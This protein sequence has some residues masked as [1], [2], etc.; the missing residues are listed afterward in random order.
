MENNF[1][2]SLLLEIHIYQNVIDNFTFYPIIILLMFFDW[3]YK[4]SLFSKF[5]LFFLLFIGFSSYIKNNAT[6]YK[7]GPD[8]CKNQLKLD[9]K[10]YSCNIIMMPISYQNEEKKENGRYLVIQKLIKEENISKNIYSLSQKSIID[11]KIKSNNE[12]Y[13]KLANNT[14]DP[15]LSIFENAKIQLNIFVEKIILFSFENSTYNRL[16]NQTENISK[17]VN[18]FFKNKENKQSFIFS[19]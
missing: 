15:S 6:I 17:E 13:I 5:F 4:K 3:K 19:K 8:F 18:N 10:M 16:M 14:F 12:Y 11:K 1:L 7:I 9:E 2:N